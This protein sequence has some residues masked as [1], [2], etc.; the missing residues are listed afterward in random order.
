VV[1]SSCGRSPSRVMGEFP[2]DYIL[3]ASC[4][5]VDVVEAF[6]EPWA[7]YY[8]GGKQRVRRRRRLGEENSM[9]PKTG[10]CWGGVGA[11]ACE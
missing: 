8:A 1:R 4:E 6:E 9:Y 3:R 5:V 11:M 2:A 10:K 7:S